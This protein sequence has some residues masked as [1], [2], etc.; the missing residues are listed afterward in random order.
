MY[1]ANKGYTV[2]VEFPE[3]VVRPTKPALWWTKNLHKKEE[4]HISLQASATKAE[5]MSK[6]AREGADPGD[7][8]DEQ[9]AARAKVASDYVGGAICGTD[10]GSEDGKA[11][12]WASDATTES[13]VVGLL[14][15]GNGIVFE[16]L[17]ASEVT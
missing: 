14:D 2:F 13:N 5:D 11:A 16:Y 4:I 7:G 9:A 1:S 15:D 17:D 6:R 8:T 10:G 3:I 12:A